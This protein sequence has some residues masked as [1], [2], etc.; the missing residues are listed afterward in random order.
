MF[1]LFPYLDDQNGEFLFF[2]FIKL[3]RHIF[4][5]SNKISISITPRLNVSIFTNVKQNYILAF[6]TSSLLHARVWNCRNGIP[7]AG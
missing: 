1:N 4:I 3:N 7:D 2:E 6:K 5:F